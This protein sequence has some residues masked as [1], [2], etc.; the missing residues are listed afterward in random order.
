MIAVF[1]PMEQLT[2]ADNYRDI[3]KSE[4]AAE[5]GSFLLQIRVH[6]Q[7]D[8]AAFSRLTQ[9]MLE[10]CEEFDAR[11]KHTTGATYANDSS[12]LPRWLAEGFWY[13]SWFIRNWTTHPAWKDRTAPHQDYY[14][15]AYERLHMLADW[16]FTGDCPYADPT[17]GF[18]P[19]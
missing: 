19:M 4:F 5:E 12:C 10:C 9:A 17:K 8:A 18:V 7:W 11:D 1:T 6:M 15:R 13:V 3:L 14:D 2:M 16:F